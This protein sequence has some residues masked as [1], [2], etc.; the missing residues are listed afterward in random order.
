MANSA[1]SNDKT[2]T[3]TTPTY[4]SIKYRNIHQKCGF[5]WHIFPYAEGS[6][7]F[8]AWLHLWI[9]S[10]KMADEIST[11]LAA[12]LI[13]VSRQLPL[14]PSSCVQFIQLK[15]RG[16]FIQQIH[17]VWPISSDKGPSTHRYLVG[18]MGVSKL[19]HNWFQQW[20]VAYSAPLY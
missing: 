19:K 8:Q 12:L 5:V 9:K 20:R 13:G 10:L 17:R 15:G 1:A 11:N 4:Q 3:T 6:C 16:I 7:I 18:H 14:N 2:V